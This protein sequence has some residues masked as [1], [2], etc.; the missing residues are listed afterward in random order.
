MEDP[1]VLTFADDQTLVEATG[2][3]QEFD[4]S[5]EARP[6][7][8]GLAKMDFVCSRDASIQFPQPH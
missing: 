2:P 1:F 3:C 6:A 4:L 8:P 7:R 5:S